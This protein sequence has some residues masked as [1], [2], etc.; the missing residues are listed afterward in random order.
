[1]STL[2]IAQFKHISAIHNRDFNGLP[3]SSTSTAVNLTGSWKFFRPKM[4]EKGSP[5][6]S[7]CPLRI[8]IA[9]YLRQ[10]AEQNPAAALET[11]REINPLPAVTGRVC[12]HFCEAACNRLEFDEAV[13]I[14]DL[15][16][17]LGDFGLDRPHRFAPAPETDLKVAVVG[18]GPAGLAAAVFL[19][20][21]GVAVEI[22]ERGQ[23]AGGLLASAI[24]AYRLPRDILRNEL[25]NLLSSYPAITLH[26]DRNIDPGELTAL[27]KEFAA[28]ILA[29]GL[30][31][32]IIPAAW[33]DNPRVIG[34]LKLLATINR[35]MEIEGDRFTVV[36]GGNAALDA[37]RSLLRRG[38]KVE[39]V[40][41]RTLAEMPAYEEEKEQARA[42][43][44]TIHQETV[45]GGLENR[46]ENLQL[47]LCRAQ[48]ENG[49]IVAGEVLRREDCDILVVA[50][51]QQAADGYLQA[52][53]PETILRAGDFAHGAATVAEALASG[54]KAAAQVWSRLND[55]PVPSETGEPLGIA[56]FTRV[57]PDY[58][59]PRP[60]VRPNLLPAR[61][62][63]AGF[64]EIRTGLSP[65][66]TCREAERCFSCGTCTTCGICW[67]F[68]PEVAIAIAPDAGSDNGKVLFDYDHCKGCGQCAAICP[69]GV[70]EMEEDL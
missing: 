42:E 18:A 26:C 30:P 46:G 54:R 17:W 5:C 24:P 27:A 10:L 11:L 41:R 39:I 61:E 67:F 35:G 31:E 7:A 43:G 29:T 37:A 47:T 48:K 45:V 36:G 44:I 16:R 50:I 68:C 57:H 51:G 34:A 28:I 12:P 59:H 19:A 3:I 38:K 53:L 63:R 2:E 65:A 66:E 9:G 14:G 25:D 49:G 13:K 40:Y 6:Q 23:E 56:D 21:R 32:S 70:I 52:K 62:R 20:R 33:Q 1:M 8:P 64:A 4:A 55:C 58:F 60:A 22:F 15:E 69:R